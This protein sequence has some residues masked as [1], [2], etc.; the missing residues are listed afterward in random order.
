MMPLNSLCSYIRRGNLGF[1]RPFRL[2]E[3]LVRL[4]E[5]SLSP[6]YAGMT[7]NSKDDWNKE[8]SSPKC[9]SI[10]NMPLALSHFMAGPFMCNY[11]SLVDEILFGQIEKVFFLLSANVQGQL[12]DKGCISLWQHHKSCISVC[13][14][15]SLPATE[16]FTLHFSAGCGHLVST[17]DFSA[18]TTTRET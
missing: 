8:K 3:S 4:R 7:Q 12:S 17:W 16:H 11:F 2:S 10:V 6:V 15:S 1:I 18:D 9:W 5:A 14:A 13:V